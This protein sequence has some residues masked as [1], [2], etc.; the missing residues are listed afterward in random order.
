MINYNQKINILN[1][2][3]RFNVKKYIHKAILVNFSFNAS[4]KRF[5]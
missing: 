3:M 5:I 4:K 2:N 1:N